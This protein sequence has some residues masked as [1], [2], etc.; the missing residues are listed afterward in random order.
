[1]RELFNEIGVPAPRSDFAFVTLNGRDLGLYVLVEGA[2]KQFLKQHFKDTSGTLYDG[3]FVQ[4]ITAPLDITYGNKKNDRSDLRAL[5]T[6][7][8]LTN[9]TK[10]FAEMSRLIDMDRFIKSLAMETLLAH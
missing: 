4:D 2:N 6:A 3:G 1:C 8:R 10:R 7:A 5:A 9:S